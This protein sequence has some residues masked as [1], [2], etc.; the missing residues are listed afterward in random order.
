[1]Y[2]RPVFSREYSE[3][4]VVRVLACNR[5]KRLN[6]VRVSK[7]RVP[8]IQA[9]DDYVSVFY[10][11]PFWGPDLIDAILNSETLQE[12]YTTSNE[13]VS[14]LEGIFDREPGVRA[15]HLFRLIR[16]TI[17][18][19]DDERSLAKPVAAAANDGISVRAGSGIS[20]TAPGS[21]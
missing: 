6:L 20:D 21:H 12:I 13:L 4:D 9:E 5:W 3:A 2:P 18:P 7:N 10:Y 8:E 19:D 14:D 15:E 1:M 11:K 16:T 17:E